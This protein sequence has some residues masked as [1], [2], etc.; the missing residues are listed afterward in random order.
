MGVDE[1]PT[2]VRAARAAYLGELL[3][4]SGMPVF[5]LLDAAR[6]PGV[7][8]VLEA[9]DCPYACL[10]SGHSGEIYKPYA[11]YLAQIAPGSRLL[12]TLLMKGWGQSI[13][14]FIGSRAEPAEL[15]TH[16]RKF[17]FVDLPGKER[18]AYFRFYDPRVMRA[19][20]PTCTPE[21]LDDWLREHLEWFVLE[22]D[23]GAQA[24]VFVRTTPER[25]AAQGISDRLLLTPIQLPDVPASQD[26]VAH[27]PDS[28]IPV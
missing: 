27:A 10:Y 1:T 12:E 16:L 8:N 21:Q 20:L 26:K 23:E 28:R 2:S 3:F 13:G 19:Y 25:R 18:R 4:R 7:V 11:P 9:G 17:L 22:A 15:L 5:A 24:K 14:Y 6:D